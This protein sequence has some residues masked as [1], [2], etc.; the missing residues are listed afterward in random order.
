MFI[1]ILKQLLT[2]VPIINITIVTVSKEFFYR[3]ITTAPDLPILLS[4]G[5]GS[6]F[7]SKY[8]NEFQRKPLSS[9]KLNILIPNCALL[10][11]IYWLKINRPFRSKS[12]S[13]IDINLEGTWTDLNLL[14]RNPILGAP[15]INNLCWGLWGHKGCC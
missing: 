5:S 14:T 12:S 10:L 13:S 2:S 3:E 11:G 8:T 6:P 1:C 9:H 7:F 15:C 4:S